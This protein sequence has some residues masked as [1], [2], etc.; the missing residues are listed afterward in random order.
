[1]LGTEDGGL[2][3]DVLHLPILGLELHLIGDLGL[4]MGVWRLLSGE[5]FL[6]SDQLEDVV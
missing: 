4:L 3:G 6:E 1:M 5:L 2:L